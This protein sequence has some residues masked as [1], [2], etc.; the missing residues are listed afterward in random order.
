M[1]VDTVA[2]SHKLRPGRLPFPYA[3]HCP[4]SYYLSNQLSF[5][6]ATRHGVRNGHIGPQQ[7]PCSYFRL[8]GPLT[9]GIVCECL[10]QGT[11]DRPGIG[12]R[13]SQHVG[14]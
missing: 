10:L 13:R 4:E 2:L 9:C 7:T 1:K 14:G 6:E 5:E 12:R 3:S 8:T 11:Q